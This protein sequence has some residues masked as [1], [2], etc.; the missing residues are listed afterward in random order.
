MIKTKVPFDVLKKELTEEEGLKYK[1]YKCT[2]GHWTIGIG[3]NLDAA[4]I[5]K[6]IGRKYSLS[7]VLTKQE[8]DAI[9]LHD[10]NNVLD[11]IEYSL[12]W[13]SEIPDYQQYVLISLVFN[14]GI[15]GLLK[16]KNTLKAWS[17]GNMDGVI[18]GL[19]HS[20]WYKQVGNRA[21]KL[22]GILERKV[23]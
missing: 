15:Y 19:E 23:I 16:F 10:L 2:A 4:Q 21:G 20:R 17:N 8:V 11:D 3:H 13:F 14:M 18:H 22:V 1:P 9:F 7:I 12:P 6:I 5:D